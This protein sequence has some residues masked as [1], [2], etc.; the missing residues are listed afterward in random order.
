M[1]AGQFLREFRR[2]YHLKRSLAHRSAVLERKEKAK[3]NQ[4]KV[5][6]PEVEQDWSRGKK[7]SHARLQALIAEI[8]ENGVKRIYKKHELQHLCRA[9]SIIDRP[10]WNKAKLSSEL[11][12][13]VA[14]YDAIPCHQQTSVY[15]VESIVQ[16]V[17]SRI[18]ILKFRRI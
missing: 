14:L 5:K 7:V 18:P 12:R 10:N 17:P 4:M 1:G 13:A 3:E 15:T 6:L 16:D 8:G 2:D 11:V 9:Y